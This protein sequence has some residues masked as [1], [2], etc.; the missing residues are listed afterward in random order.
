MQSRITLLERGRVQ[1]GIRNIL[2]IIGVHYQAQFKF[3]MSEFTIKLKM[4][5]IK[6]KA[7]NHQRDK[8]LNFSSHGI[9]N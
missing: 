9:L 1:K 5:M 3:L 8:M 7:L 6:M 4:I 2:I